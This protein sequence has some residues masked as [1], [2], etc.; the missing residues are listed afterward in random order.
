MRDLAGTLVQVG[1]PDPDMRIELPLLDLFS[2][3]GA[4]KS[5]WYGDCLPS[6]D[7]PRPH[8][9]VP[10]RQARP[11]AVHHRDDRARRGRGGVRQDAARRGTAVG[12]RGVTVRRTSRTMTHPAVSSAGSPAAVSSGRR[13]IRVA[14]ISPCTASPAG[15]CCGR[16]GRRCSSTLMYFSPARRSASLRSRMTSGNSASA[17]VSNR[18]VVYRSWTPSASDDGPLEL[19]QIGGVGAADGVVEEQRA[20]VPVLVA[21][22]V[23]AAQ[24][25]HRAVQRDGGGE[26]LAAGEHVAHLPDRDPLGAQHG[27]RL[28]DLDGDALRLQ[29]RADP[30]QQQG[31]AVAAQV[32]V[33]LHGRAGRLVDDL[34]EPLGERGLVGVLEA[35]PQELLART[36]RPAPPAAGTAAGRSAAWPAPTRPARAAGPR[37]SRGCAPAAPARR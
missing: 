15:S 8:R 28:E 26:Q 29:R 4:L 21:A 23:V 10:Q 22:P 12:R 6:R 32:G 14:V 16:P 30:A 37:S 11:G 2:R 25:G 34:A 19:Q 1:V 3:G 33:L 31:H 13:Y 20:G 9:P 18:P 17:V 36:T 35:D 27:V 24:R 7:F 5:S